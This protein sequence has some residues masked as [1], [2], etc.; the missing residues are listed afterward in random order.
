[1][2]YSYLLIFLI[3]IPPKLDSTSL[4]DIHPHNLTNLKLLIILLKLSY[5]QLKLYIV[6]DIKTKIK[7]HSYSD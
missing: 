2:L 5:V 6:T 4:Y 7:N 1:M 3:T